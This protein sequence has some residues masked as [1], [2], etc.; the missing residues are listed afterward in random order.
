MMRSIIILCLTLSISLPLAAQSDKAQE[1]ELYLKGRTAYNEKK[2]EEALEN[3]S[4]FRAVNKKYLAKHPELKLAINECIKQSKAEIK[5]QR[6][7]KKNKKDGLIISAIAMPPSPLVVLVE[8]DS[9]THENLNSLQAEYNAFRRL[10]LVQFQI[11]VYCNHSSDAE[12]N[13]AYAEERVLWIMSE[14]AKEEFP[15]YLFIVNIADY[16][17]A[18]EQVAR[19]MNMNG[20]APASSV[21]FEFRIAEKSPLYDL[22]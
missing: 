18:K 1:K 22:D 20:E 10:K 8:H 19:M 4:A 21:A 5:R 17:T 13:Q 16:E 7:L 15:D 2:Y 14:L 12:A 9:L 11:N 6:Q 3:L